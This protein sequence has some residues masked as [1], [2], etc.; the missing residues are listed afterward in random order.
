MG[1]A[2]GELRSSS[3]LSGKR[4]SRCLLEGDDVR[5]ALELGGEALGGALATLFYA[6]AKHRTVVI[7][8][9]AWVGGIA[10][11][12]LSGALAGLMPAIRAA[13]AHPPRR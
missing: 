10:A 9:E 5:R 8:T 12:I 4:V 11:A 3:S 6:H 7:A 1:D 13:A 2:R